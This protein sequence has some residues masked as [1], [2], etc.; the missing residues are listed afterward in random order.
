MSKREAIARY[1]IIVKKLRKHPASFEEIAQSLEKESEL[2]SYNFNISKRTFQRDIKDI[3]SLYN[4]DIQYNRSLKSYYIDSSDEKPEV[5]ERILETFDIFN[6]I[7]ITDRL[8]QYILF[9][10]RKSLG[11]ENLYGLLHAIK[12]NLHV[13]FTYEKFWEDSI[14]ERTAEPYAL[15]EFKNR[16]YLMAKETGIDYLKCFGL[17][18]ISNLDITNKK[19]T[20]EKYLNAEEH[21]RY[22]FGIMVPEDDEEPQDVILSFHPEQGKYIKTLPLHDTQEILADD[23]NEILV[24]LTLCVTFDFI[25]EL[26]SFG[27]YMKVMQPLSLVKE[28]KEAHQR[29]VK[30]Y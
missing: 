12:N 24:K 11:T 30:R 4:I 21:F 13:T 20:P 15:K 6:A 28:I 2:Q 27:E 25:M 8:S 14:T 9:E 17:D 29:A 26:L 1:A 3:C 18:R 5:S 7:N 16:W 19:F 10:K 23:E 22:C